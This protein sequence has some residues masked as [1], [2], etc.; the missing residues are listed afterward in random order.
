MIYLT[1][2]YCGKIRFYVES[3]LCT[4]D[5]CDCEEMKEQLNAQLMGWA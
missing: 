3:N 5:I 2:L 1:G 4:L